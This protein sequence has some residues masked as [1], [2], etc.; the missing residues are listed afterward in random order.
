MEDDYS[1]KRFWNATSHLVFHC[2]KQ[3][4]STVISM[5]FDYMYSTIVTIEMVPTAA[6]AIN[7]SFM[8]SPPCSKAHLSCFGYSL[9]LHLLLFFR[10]IDVTVLMNREYCPKFQ[11]DPKPLKIRQTNTRLLAVLIYRFFSSRSGY[12]Q[13]TTSLSK[14]EGCFFIGTHFLCSWLVNSR[15]TDQKQK[16]YKTLKYW[17]QI[18]RSIMRLMRILENSLF[19]GNSP[20]GFPINFALIKL[21]HFCNKEVS[22][23]AYLSLDHL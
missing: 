15:I 8:C 18:R 11:S 13:Q 3:T 20:L 5:I 2:A 4:R 16:I 10:N 23:P 9:W 6:L 21:S 7:R 1:H 12:Q 22:F 14:S 17:A 19:P